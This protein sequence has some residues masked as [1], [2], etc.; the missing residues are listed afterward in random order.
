M[1]IIFSGDKEII[2]KIRFQYPDREFGIEKEV[3][4]AKRYGVHLTALAFS[5]VKATPADENSSQSVSRQILIDAILKKMVKIVRSSDIIGEFGNNEIV[6]L[7]PFT[8][9]DEAQRT[10]KRCLQLLYLEP[11]EANGIA[12]TIKMAGVAVSYDLTHTPDAEVF[13]NE[14]SNELMQMEIRIRNIQNLLK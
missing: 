10:L 11:I 9:P 14:L 13:I 4:R 8:P 6:V 12:F 5:L 2:N 1:D 3:A 7:L